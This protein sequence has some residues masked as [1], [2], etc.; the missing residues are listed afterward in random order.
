MRTNVINLN[1]PILPTPPSLIPR[2]RGLMPSNVP[3]SLKANGSP[4]PAAPRR[5]VEDS[6]IS[7]RVWTEIA[8]PHVLPIP[9]R[10]S[11]NPYPYVPYPNFPKSLGSASNLILGTLSFARTNSMPRRPDLLLHCHLQDSKDS[12]PVTTSFDISKTFSPTSVGGSL[13]TLYPITRSSCTH[14]LFALRLYNHIPGRPPPLYT[15]QEQGICHHQ[16]SDKAFE[17]KGIKAIDVTSVFVVIFGDLWQ[18]F[19]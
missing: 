14:E 3:T 2:A 11:R 13:E 5:Q 7:R 9:A 15:A 19:H 17:E 10:C 12:V 16:I 1:Y 18:K 8:T 6:G 4:R